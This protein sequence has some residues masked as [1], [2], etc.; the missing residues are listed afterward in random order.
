MDRA[1]NF[2]FGIALLFVS[3]FWIYAAF[4]YIHSIVA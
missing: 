2:A 4:R 1:L 3:V